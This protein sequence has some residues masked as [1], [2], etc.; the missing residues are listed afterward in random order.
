[1]SNHQKFLFIP[2]DHF[3]E[4]V[5]LKCGDQLSEKR[6][7]NLFNQTTNESFKFFNFPSLNSAISLNKSE[8]YK[9]LTLAN[10]L[11]DVKL[12]DRPSST[13]GESASGELTQSDDSDRFEFD[14]EMD[15]LMQN[16][17]SNKLRI[18]LSPTSG[19][20]LDELSN[21]LQSSDLDQSLL[22]LFGTASQK[23]DLIY[24]KNCKFD[25][26]AGHLISEHSQ[27]FGMKNDV[28]DFVKSGI[29]VQLDSPMFPGDIKAKR[30]S[31]NVKKNCSVV[32]KLLRD[33][34]EAGHIE[35]V[36]FKPSAVSP[37]NLVPKSKGSPRLIHNLKTLNTFVKRGSS[38]K[39]LNVLHLVKPEFSRKTYFCKLD[40]YGYK[41]FFS[42]LLDLRIGRT[43]GFLSRI[44]T[45]YLIHFVSLI[46]LPLIIFRPFLRI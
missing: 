31:K 30:N 42:I 14:E 9:N 23:N 1:M 43:L 20:F 18:N 38:V 33:L 29:P 37:L 6:Q 8:I 10:S 45:M 15:M 19:N 40:L 11:D 13:Q 28:L 34:N 16:L 27:E 41:W 4:A 39:H 36:N 35:K 12:F 22:D 21:E 17:D 25:F 26:T 24:Q 46:S 5:D 32:R 3:G 7:A 44:I 2:P